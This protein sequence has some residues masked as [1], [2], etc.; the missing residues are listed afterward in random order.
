M[1]LSQFVG[2]VSGSGTTPP[3]QPWGDFNITLTGT[4]VGTVFPERSFDNGST[5]NRLSADIYGSPVAWTGS[6]TW[7]ATEAEQSVM[8]RLNYALS[9]GTLGYRFSQ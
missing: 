1:A 4:W 9:S 5:W 8:W 2:T 3:C 7:M 6:G